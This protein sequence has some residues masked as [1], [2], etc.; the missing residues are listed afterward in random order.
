MWE[1]ASFVT[2]TGSPLLRM[3]PRDLSWSRRLSGTG[4]GSFGFPMR[5]QDAIPKGTMR[6]LLAPTS[7]TLA[8]TWGDHVVFAGL[9]QQTAYDRDSG[10]VTA[11]TMELRSLFEKRMTGGVNQYGSVWNFSYTDRSPAGAVRAI[12]ARAMAPSSEWDLPI[13]LPSD[14]SGAYSR[15]VD[16]FETVTIA[17]LLKE[18]EDQSGITVDFRPYLSGGSLRWETRLL[19]PVS[20]FGTTDLPVT[21]EGS[22][23]TG[24]GV[25]ED[26]VKQVTGV[27]A[28]GN[29]TGA[30]MLTA[31]SPTGGSGA[32]E[33]PVRDEKRSAK[34]LKSAGQLQRFADAEYA[35]W[36]QVRE[37]WSFKSQVGDDLSPAAL[38]PGRLL[39][40]DVRGDEWMPDGMRSRR[41]I[42]LSGDLSLTVTPEVDDVS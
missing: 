34:D 16:F 14:G 26:G 28:L 15:Q 41:V 20:T 29:G 30:D 12:L 25:V 27:L 39:R 33:I 9:V 8:V 6:G 21:V 19:G 24:L 37:S 32:V 13:D 36:S 40:M 4:R 3:D 23:V 1:C 31:Y 42:A 17:D 22:H 2:R 7:R 11:S 18:L 35:K 5:D 10:V 38:Q